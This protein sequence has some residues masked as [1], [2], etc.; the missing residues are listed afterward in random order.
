MPYNGKTAYDYVGIDE[1]RPFAQTEKKRR[2]LSEIA[3][4]DYLGREPTR[5]SNPT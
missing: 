5:G 3:L 1:P 2:Q 4:A